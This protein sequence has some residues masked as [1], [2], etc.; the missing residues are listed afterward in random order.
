MSFINSMPLPYFQIDQDFTI[1][2]ASESAWS[3]FQPSDSLLHLIDEESQ[4]KAKLLLFSKNI[5]SIELVMKTIDSPY[6]LIKLTCN[7]EKDNG[8]IIC[9]K[10]DEEMERLIETVDKHRH[11]LAETNFELLEQKEQ[12]EDYHAR[13]SELSLP[14]IPLSNEIALIPIYG[15]VTKE[16]IDHT[17]AR[18][19]K[20]VYDSEAEKVLFDF[21]GVSSLTQEGILA[22]GNMIESLSLF[23]TTS[24]IIGLNPNQ[25][26]MLHKIIPNI[27]VTYLKNLKY[28][29]S[30]FLGT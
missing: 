23:G 4:Q 30:R 2:A 9:T 6:A 5:L 7:W 26:M 3:L 25:T 15:D 13:I 18:L 22:L 17:Q 12:L 14:L 10:Q 16:I 19:L 11:R 28:A 20:D 1:L 27:P 24:Y 8:H 21:H 29:I